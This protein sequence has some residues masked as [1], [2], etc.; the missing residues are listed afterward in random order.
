MDRES[1]GQ[2]LRAC[3]DTQREDAAS[4]HGLVGAAR[5]DGV[6]WRDIGDALGVPASTAWQQYHGGNRIV[7][8]R[9]VHTERR[10]VR[11]ERRKGDG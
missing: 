8:V 11:R 10:G 5:D 6:P 3:A 9:P 4:L 2:V 1:H 7:V